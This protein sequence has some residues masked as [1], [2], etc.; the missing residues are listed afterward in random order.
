MGQC[1]EPLWGPGRS[2][3]IL[4][5]FESHGDSESLY[6]ASLR[7]MIDACTLRVAQTVCCWLVMHIDS[8]YKV[9]NGTFFFTASVTLDVNTA[10]VSTIVYCVYNYLFRHSYSD[11]NTHSSSCVCWTVF[12]ESRCGC[13]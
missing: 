10:R 9:S 11:V 2:K 1:C 8:Y 4:L 5:H 6:S 7:Q 13:D 12:V 3:H